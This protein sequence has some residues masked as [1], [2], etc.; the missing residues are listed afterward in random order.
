MPSS[1]SQ[2][3]KILNVLSLKRQ[4]IEANLSQLKMRLQQVETKIVYLSQP[5]EHSGPEGSALSWAKANCKWETWREGRRD[6]LRREAAELS[7]DIALLQGRLLRLIVQSNAMQAL[8]VKHQTNAARK[9]ESNRANTR[10]E[11]WVTAHK[12]SNN[13][14]IIP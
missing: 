4:H 3:E 2:L 14:D 12:E 6:S 11:T 13:F 7:R 10:L 8:F 5:T 9:L 1:H